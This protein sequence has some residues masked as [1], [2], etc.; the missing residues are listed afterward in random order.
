[1]RAEIARLEDLKQKVESAH[2]RQAERWP[3]MTGQI[4]LDMTRDGLRIQ[5]VDEQN[6][7]MFDS[8]SAAVKPYMRELLRAIGQVL[9][10]V[11]NRLTLEG[12]TDARRTPAA[13]AATA[14]GSCRPTA[15]TPRAANWSPAAC[16][17]TACCACR[18]WPRAS[19]STAPTRASAQQ[20]P[21]QHHRDEPRGRGP[22]VP[23]RPDAAEALNEDMPSRRRRS[24]SSRCRRSSPGRTPAKQRPP[25]ADDQRRQSPRA[26]RA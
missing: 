10:E 13:N 4:R 22:H 17:T 6:R 24:W 2:R 25:V 16:P 3:A 18:A 1:M 11:P 7:P 9:N 14:T 19:R 23:H 5:I 20:P 8:G 26:Y 15:P 12:H 21:H